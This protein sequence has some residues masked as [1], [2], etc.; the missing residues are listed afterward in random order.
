MTDPWLI[1][2]KTVESVEKSKLD[3]EVNF[4]RSLL[5]DDF[6]RIRRTEFGALII[7]HVKIDNIKHS[8]S[9]AMMQMMHEMT[10]QSIMAPSIL[11]FAFARKD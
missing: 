2:K 10:H 9:S 5:G 11:L 1:I 7:V 8:T 4:E 3:G 6:P